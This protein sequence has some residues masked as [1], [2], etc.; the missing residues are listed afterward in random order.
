[1]VCRSFLLSLLIA[2]T[3]FPR[4]L[5]SQPATVPQRPATTAAEAQLHFVCN[6][7]YSQER[8]REQM[9]VLRGVIGRYHGEALGE[10]TWVLVRSGDWKEIKS[11]LGLDPASPA[12]SVLKVHQTFVEEALVAPVPGRSAELI[13]HWSSSIDELLQLAVTHEM[14]HALCNEEDEHRADTSGRVLRAGGA[15]QCR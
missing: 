6:T 13:K 9:K 3:L 12:F 10:W 1:V 5:L 14:G 15:V 7:G 8:C 11:R 2:F 4:A